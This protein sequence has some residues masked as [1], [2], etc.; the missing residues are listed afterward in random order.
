MVGL[1]LAGSKELDRIASFVSLPSLGHGEQQ[2]GLAR[3]QR[4]VQLQAQNL[5]QQMAWLNLTISRSS[6]AFVVM[7][8][9]GQSMSK[10]TINF[11]EQ[12]TSFG[13]GDG[14][15]TGDG[16]GHGGGNGCGF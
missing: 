15:G 12:K 1:W 8:P 11:E 10:R 16:N 3:S 7:H 14:D 13:A 2:R 5:I 6:Q 4:V 9:L